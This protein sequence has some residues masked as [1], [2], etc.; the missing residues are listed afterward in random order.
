MQGIDSNLEKNMLE[1]MLIMDNAGMEE[2]RGKN[3]LLN[4]DEGYNIAPLKPRPTSGVENEQQL[5]D[6]L[7]T[8]RT[9]NGWKKRMK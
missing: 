5:L 8:L 1:N 3:P 6:D 9:M 2:A 7:Y 4:D